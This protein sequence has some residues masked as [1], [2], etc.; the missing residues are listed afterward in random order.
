VKYS[1]SKP[2]IPIQ[3]GKGDSTIATD[4]Y[5]W[6]IAAIGP[7]KLEELGMQP[8]RILEFAEKNCCVEVFFN[9]PEGYAVK[10]KGFDF[11]PE[12]NLARRGV[13]SSEWTAQMVIAYKIMADYYYKKG[14][15]AKGHAYEMK[16]DE[17]LST[18]GK[19]VISSPSPTG[20][21]Y[22]CLPYATEECVDTGHAWRT[23]KGNSTGSVAATAYTLFAYYSYN[24]LELK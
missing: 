16:A 1:Y 7:E 22:G 13:I 9:R 21:G 5:A 24:P 18:L 11:A 2:D 19:M 12:R 6:S 14:L 23:P 10:I 17:Y 8:E 15:K 4:T 3:R 20:Q